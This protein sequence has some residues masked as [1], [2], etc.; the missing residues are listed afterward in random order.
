MTLK[1]DDV[2][3]GIWRNLGAGQDG[4]EATKTLEPGEIQMTSEAREKLYSPR[5]HLAQ[6]LMGGVDEITYIDDVRNSFSRT[7]S[8]HLLSGRVTGR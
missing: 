1:H 3:G 6:N 4:F 2:V 8:G 7:F 5:G